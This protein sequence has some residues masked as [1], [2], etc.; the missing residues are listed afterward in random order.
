MK[1]FALLAAT[2]AAFVLAACS[3]PQSPQDAM[4]DAIEAGLQLPPGASALSAYGRSYAYDRESREIV[5]VYVIPA[6][7][8]PPGVTCEPLSSGGAVEC[9]D[10]PADLPAGQ[11][12][13]V[14]DMMA[15]PDVSDG[16]CSILTLRYDPQR[17][18]VKE[19]GCN[20]HA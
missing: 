4:M 2:S 20:G 11:R 3:P 16:G 12:R 13:W 17:E 8:E 19:I 15:L 6:S 7:Q 5:G 1:R 9:P 10:M 18:R 14:K